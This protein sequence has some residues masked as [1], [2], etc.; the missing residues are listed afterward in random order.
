ML[1]VLTRDDFNNN[2][3]D[4]T[5]KGDNHRQEVVFDKGAITVGLPKT[6]GGTS[7]SGDLGQRRWRGPILDRRTE[8]DLIR[9]A[10]SDDEPAKQK[11]VESFHRLILKIVGQ[12][13][14]PPHN[15]LM[16]AG[17]LGFEEAIS[18]FNE[19]RGYRLKTYA[20]PWIRKHIR[21]CIKDWRKE[22]A[23]GETRQDRYVFSNPRATA[24]EIVAA[25]G[26]SIADAE[27]AIA[28]LNARHE[29]YDTG[30]RFDEDGNFT[31]PPTR[32]RT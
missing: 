10:K 14:G 4:C 7:T 23:A 16:A 32:Y 6:A 26:G 27:R 2:Y 30:E 19:N 17:L 5:H 3:F 11:L 9:K 20:E 13:S 28:R 1:K 8:R 25:V 15:D 24:E 22:G 12:Y 31:G 18:R 21:L 29:S